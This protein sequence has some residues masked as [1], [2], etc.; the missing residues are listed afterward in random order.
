MPRKHQLDH[1]PFQVLPGTAVRLADFETGHR[2]EFDE[3]SD[4]KK[5]LAEDISSLKNSQEL[6]WAD[7]RYAVLII[8]QAMDAAGK[9]GTIKHVMSGVNPQGCE[10]H[11][12]GPPS[13]EELGHH[14]LWR[15]MRYLP[16][17]GRIGIFNRS[18]YEETL[19][20]RVHPEYL[21]PQKLPPGPRDQQFWQQRFEDINNFE[22][23]LNRNGTCVIKFFL[24]VSKKEQKKRFQERLNNPEK[25]WKFNSKDLEE[26][27]HWDSYMK[28]FEETLTATSSAW[29]PWYVIPA[30]D[31]WFTRACV[32]DIITSRIDELDLS[33]PTVSKEE[34]ARLVV[35]R[36][37]L[38]ADD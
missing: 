6:L 5:S 20:V 12:F 29:A 34:E 21:E 2:D 33:F 37:K 28:C 17:R 10:V 22:H 3:K 25:H 23:T 16:A 19:V 15:P 14:F 1:T 4:A 31:K 11:S 24:H 18:Y 32:A 9:D 36:K 13:T 8:L 30:D 35:S 38:E 27:N 7:K 26:R